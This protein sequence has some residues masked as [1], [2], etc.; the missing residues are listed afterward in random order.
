[1]G[2]CAER[3]LKLGWLNQGAMVSTRQKA[4]ASWSSTPTTTDAAS[5]TKLQGNTL[6]PR[7]QAAG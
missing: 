5:Q 3:A 4:M 2:R 7:C 6:P 1:M